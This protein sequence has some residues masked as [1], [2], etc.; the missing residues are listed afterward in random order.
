MRRYVSGPPGPPG[1]PAA[2]SH[3]NSGFNPEEVAERVLRLMTGECYRWTPG[4]RLKQCSVE[5]DDNCD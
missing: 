1:P 3:D 4:Y 5:R 2:P